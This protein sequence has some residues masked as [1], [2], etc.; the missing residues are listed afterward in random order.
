MFSKDIIF[1]VTLL[2]VAAARYPSW[3]V[4]SPPAVFLAPVSLAVM[5]A[6]VRAQ[7]RPSRLGFALALAV[8]GSAISKVV[9][10]V[11]LA[12]YPGLRLLDAMLRRPDRTH[13]IWF[14]ILSIAIVAYVFFM[15]RNFGNL[16]LTEWAPG[17]ESWQRFQKKGWSEIHQVLPLLLKD[18][19]LLL[20]AAGI[21]KLRDWGLFATAVLAVT[22]NFLFSFLFTPTP[23][24]LLMLLAAYLITTPGIR[25]GAVKLI[26]IGALLFLPHHI[27]HDPGEWQMMLLWVLTL[28]GSALVVLRSHSEASG[29][30]NGAAVIGREWRNI[31]IIM[32][33]GSLSLAALEAGDFRLGKKRIETGSCRFI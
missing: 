2:V 23:T 18:V 17:P 24:A 15:V 10:V 12:S 21:L 8:M 4:E 31:A 25:K 28:G 19:G 9:S 5:Y 7:E 1:T 16:F 11:V 3:I 13:F 20:I 22:S 26:V 33:V 29:S 14:G 32:F 27:R 30:P 6:V